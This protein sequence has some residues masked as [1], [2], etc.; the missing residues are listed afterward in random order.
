MKIE[1]FDYHLPKSL[2]AQRPSSERGASRLM[3]VHQETGVIEHRSFQEIIHYL[4]PGDLLTVNNTRV[5]PARLVGRK[6]TGGRCEVLLFPKHNGSEGQ[7][8]ALIT[9]VGGAGK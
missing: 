4:H 2:I 7:W 1:E 5:L 9:G 8:D 6:D 3:V